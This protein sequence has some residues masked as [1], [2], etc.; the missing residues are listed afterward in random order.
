MYYSDVGIGS[1]LS[2]MTDRI[3]GHASVPSLCCSSFKDDMDMGVRFGLVE[4]PWALGD[5]SVWCNIRFMAIL[6]M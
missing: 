4:E 2:S 3:F 5:G 6:V 1:C